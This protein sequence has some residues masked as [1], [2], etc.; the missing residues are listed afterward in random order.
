MKTTKTTSVDLLLHPVR[1]RIIQ[2]L[3]GDRRMTTAAL[4]AELSDVS[5]ATLYRHVAALADA[6]VLE[7]T[8]EQRVRGAVERTYALHLPAAQLDEEELAAM[9]PGDHR[10]AFMAFVAGLLAGFD[11]YLER[12]D[13][14]LRRDGVGYR[15]TALWLSDE[16]FAAFVADLRAVFEARAANGPREGRTRRMVTTVLM[17][18]VP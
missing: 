9:T 10:Q 1:L 13:T 14:D 18:S 15:Q 8:G 6:G 7:V 17:P 16:E 12:G 3:L 5:T 11:R 2:A 4:A